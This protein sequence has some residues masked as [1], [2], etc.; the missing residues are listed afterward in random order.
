MTVSTPDALSRIADPKAGLL[1]DGIEALEMLQS[2]LGQMR[3]DFRQCNGAVAA[4]SVAQA[5]LAWQNAKSRVDALTALTSGDVPEGNPPRSPSV[6]SLKPPSPPEANEDDDKVMSDSEMW[7]KIAEIIGE[8]KKKYLDIYEQASKNALEFNDELNKITA[9]LNKL[10]SVN[11]KGDKVTLK[12]AELKAKLEELK[13]KFSLPNPAGVL[14]PS[15][16]R[17]GAIDG[18]TKEEAEQWLKELGLPQSSLKEFPEGSGKYVVTLDLGPLDS[19]ISGLPSKE[20]LNPIELD[21]WKTGFLGQD[22]AFKT[23]LQTLTQKYTTANAL[24]DNMTKVLSGAIAACKD[25]ISTY[26]K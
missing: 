3:D 24:Y 11:D 12:V 4:D 26:F 19:M 7:A 5:R 16:G 8:I 20:E 14:F 21:T 9:E 6:N 13:K 23:K 25:T 10:I 18:A 15:P 22:N 2:A 1:T 17:D